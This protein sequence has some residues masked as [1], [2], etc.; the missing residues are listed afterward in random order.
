MPAVFWNVH[1]VDFQ[2]KKLKKG[3]SLLSRPE[4]V[5]L[6]TQLD[7]CLYKQMGVAFCQNKVGG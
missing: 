3:F 7:K 1:I 6:P 4:F 2:D 5:N